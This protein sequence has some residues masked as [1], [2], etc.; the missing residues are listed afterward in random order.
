MKQHS[1]YLNENMWVGIMGFVIQN[2]IVDL[3]P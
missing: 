1:R 2:I 3:S